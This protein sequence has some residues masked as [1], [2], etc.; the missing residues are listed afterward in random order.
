MRRWIGLVPVVA[1]VLVA[2]ACQPQPGP[3]PGVTPSP[4]P[5]ETGVTPSPR[6]EETEPAPP[7][8]PGE[9]FLVDRVGPD[10]YRQHFTLLLEQVVEPGVVKASYTY[11]Y[12][13]YVQ[14][15]PMTLLLDLGSGQLSEKEVSVVLLEPQR[16]EI[17]PE[18]VQAIALENGLEPGG[19]C[20]QVKILLGPET[21]NRFAWEVI[22]PDAAPTETTPNPV[23][24]VVV[25]VE[26]G[27]LYAVD[28]VKPMQS[29]GE[30]L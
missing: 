24:R 3:T 16:F 26:G 2:A 9:R 1:L 12:E 5:E 4:R 25:D 29:H 6:P 15:Y 19:G 11:T 7:G 20:C 17:G 22:S 30:P 18:Q 10:Y 23:F 8:S 13:P 21:R 28:T 14:G 27:A